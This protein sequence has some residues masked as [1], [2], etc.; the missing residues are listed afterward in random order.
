MSVHR[1]CETQINLGRTSENEAVIG[2]FVI[3]SSGKFLR[4]KLSILIQFYLALGIDGSRRGDL[5]NRC[6]D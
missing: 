2:A 5:T 1:S 6:C 3:G 4:S